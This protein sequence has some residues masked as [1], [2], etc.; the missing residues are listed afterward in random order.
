MHAGF[1]GSP[2]IAQAQFHTYREENHN[3]PVDT[4]QQKHIPVPERDLTRKAGR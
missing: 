3:C 4:F 1:R 2:R